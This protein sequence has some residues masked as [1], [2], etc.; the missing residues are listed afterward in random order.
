MISK[1]REGSYLQIDDRASG[2]AYREVGLHKCGHCPIQLNPFRKNHV[3][4]S[5]CDQY[6]CVFCSMPENRI[7]CEP[8]DKVFDDALSALSKGRPLI[9]PD[10]F[11]R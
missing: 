8:V 7:K 9:L 11:T 3:W 10:R 6:L 4:C 1:S 5:G 2:G